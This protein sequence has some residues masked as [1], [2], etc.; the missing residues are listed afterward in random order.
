MWRGYATVIEWRQLCCTGVHSECKGS[1]I[2]DQVNRFPPTPPHLEHWHF[3][4]VGNIEPNDEIGQRPAVLS[5]PSL[6]VIGSSW[7]GL[8]GWV[9]TSKRCDECN[10]QGIGW[11]SHPTRHPSCPTSTPVWPG[12]WTSI[13]TTAV[14]GHPHRGPPVNVRLHSGNKRLADCNDTSQKIS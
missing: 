12:V 6:V 8:D 3:C 1:C 14:Q 2:V 9:L 4:G 7:R 5:L 11:S 10:E 13:S